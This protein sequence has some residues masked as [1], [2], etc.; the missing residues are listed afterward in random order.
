MAPENSVADQLPI[1]PTPQLP[2]S[3][4]RR[5]RTFLL[6][7][8]KRLSSKGMDITE[9]VKRINFAVAQYE[10][11]LC[12]AAQNPVLSK[13]HRLG[14]AQRFRASR[15][16]GIAAPLPKPESESSWSHLSANRVAQ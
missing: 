15:P 8:V 12:C 7:R 9:Y 11:K 3:D 16:F 2:A 4:D 6:R 14:A 1:Q 5:C 10:Q 13:R